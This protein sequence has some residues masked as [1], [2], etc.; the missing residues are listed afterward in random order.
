MGAYLEHL[1]VKVESADSL[2]GQLGE[3][4]H[5][6]HDPAQQLLTIRL[7]GALTLSKPMS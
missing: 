7:R 2:K 5:R 4:V 3:F 6:A 1:G